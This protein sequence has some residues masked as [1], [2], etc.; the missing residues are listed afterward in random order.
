MISRKLACLAAVVPLG[1]VPVAA[2]ASFYTGEE[3]YAVCTAQ[4][5]SKAYV[6]NT[7]ECIAYITGTIDA[8]NTIRRTNKLRSCIPADV[9]IAQLR[10]AT[11]AYLRDNPQDRSA[12]ASELVFA[13]TRRQW[14]CGKKK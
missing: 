5:E 6:E 9:T 8:F 11:V 12:S 2:G 1:L 3:L 4:R 7:Y 10:S 13:A 14:P